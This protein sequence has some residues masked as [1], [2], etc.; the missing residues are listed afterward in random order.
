MLSSLPFS[1]TGLFSSVNILFSDIITLFLDINLSSSVNVL[2]FATIA[3][4]FSTGTLSLNASIL[5]PNVFL[6]TYTPPLANFSLL[7]A[8]FIPFCI[9]QLVFI[10]H[11]WFID[12]SYLFSSFVLVAALSMQ[13]KLEVQKWLKITLFDCLT[14]AQP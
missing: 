10:W 13:T 3:L 9:L 8:L 12:T 7:S 14:L 6:S 2:S 1:H 5:S 4:F 11:T